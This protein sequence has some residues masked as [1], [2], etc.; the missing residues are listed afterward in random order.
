MNS[1][2]LYKIDEE[3]YYLLNPV[4]VFSL[5]EETNDKE[6]AFKQILDK[7]YSRKFL[8][9]L[10]NDFYLENHLGNKWW[11][12]KGIENRGNNRIVFLFECEDDNLKKEIQFSM[13][14]IMTKMF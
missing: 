13:K 8:K 12:L 1:V 2:V 14:F 5:K 10:M 11:E 3:D 7:L 4:Y 6:N 9:N